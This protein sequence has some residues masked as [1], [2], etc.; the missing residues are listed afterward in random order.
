MKVKFSDETTEPGCLMECD[1]G[2]EFFVDPSSEENLEWTRTQLI[3][4]CPNCKTINP[5]KDHG[6]LK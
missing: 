5:N 4:V 6:D 3:E 1:C 2:T